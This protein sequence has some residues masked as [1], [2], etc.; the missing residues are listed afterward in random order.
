M[1]RRAAFFIVDLARQADMV[2]LG[3]CCAATAFGLVMISSA[4]NYLQSGRHLMVQGI[5]ALLGIVL[6]FVVAQIDLTEVVK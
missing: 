6:Y 2:L 3:L 4:T 5:A 1:I